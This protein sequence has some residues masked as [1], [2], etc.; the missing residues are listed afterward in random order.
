MECAAE[1]VAALKKKGLKGQVLDVVTTSDKGMAANI[2]SDKM[3]M[4]ISTNGKHRAVF[5][6][7]KV[8]DNLNP[9]GIDFG[10]WKNDLFSP[11]GY[12]INKTYF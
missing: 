10:S 7:N 3:G 4:N 11:T 9:N 12:S 6:E 2:W 8:Y 1:I 5:F